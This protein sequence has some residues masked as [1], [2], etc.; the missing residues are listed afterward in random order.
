MRSPEERA[1]E[2]AAWVI[3]GLYKVALWSLAEGGYGWEVSLA[4]RAIGRSQHYS[5]ALDVVDAHRAIGI[6]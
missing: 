1:R 2:P 6:N 5:E 3:R 4:G